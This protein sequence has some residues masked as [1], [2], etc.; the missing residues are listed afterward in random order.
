MKPEENPY[1]SPQ[2]VEP[3]IVADAPS[4]SLQPVVP[5]ESGHRRAM[6]A[7][8]LL[9][10]CMVGGAFGI[11]S[12]AM[13]LDFIQK[14]Q[15]GLIDQADFV[16]S[17]QGNDARQKSVAIFQIIVRISSAIAFLIWIHRTYRNLRALGAVNL[18]YSPGW[19]V[20]YFFIPILNLF[21]PY[22]VMKEIWHCSEPNTEEMPSE[23]TST[24]A[25]LGWWWASWI[26]MI[27]LAQITNR[28]EMAAS[29]LPDFNLLSYANIT[30]NGV[31]VLGAL[32]AILVVRGVDQRQEARYRR[33]SGGGE[34]RFLGASMVQ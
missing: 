11:V 9:A 6:W 16:H 23:Y 14:F 2:T 5:Y 22:Q 21:R 1:L 29:K 4:A 12:N 17:A 18:K 25:L 8:S 33:L 3:M 7:M 26:L 28:I 10:L 20:G 24:S 19:A 30:A 32:L 15:S 27:I 13:Q 31:V 34:E